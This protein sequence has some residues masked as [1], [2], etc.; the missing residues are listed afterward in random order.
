MNSSQF[1]RWLAQ[2]GCTFESAKGGHLTVRRGDKK[3]TLPQHGGHKQLKTGL[4]RGIM[5]QLGIDE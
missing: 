5:K 4:M 3:A 1:R 2:R